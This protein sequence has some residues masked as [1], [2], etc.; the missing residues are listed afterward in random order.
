[1]KK[2]IFAFLLLTTS[3]TWAQNKK[4]VSI[5]GFNP[6]HVTEENLGIAFSYEHFLDSKGIL[7]K[8]IATI[9]QLLT[10][11]EKL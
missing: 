2:V 5:Y 6:F 10:W 4:P 8:K 11:N 1:M 7:L 3:L 9:E